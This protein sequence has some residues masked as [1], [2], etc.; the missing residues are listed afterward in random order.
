ML[1]LGLGKFFDDRSAGIRSSFP[2]RTAIPAHV[3][4]TFLLDCWGEIEKAKATK[5]TQPEDEKSDWL[6]EG[7][8][9]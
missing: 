7:L 6:P 2:A 1:V 9:E 3:M 8:G 4:E 5:P